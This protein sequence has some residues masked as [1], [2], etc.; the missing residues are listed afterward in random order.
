MRLNLSLNIVLKPFWSF[1]LIYYQPHIPLITTD[2]YITSTQESSGEVI[3]FCYRLK[4]STIKTAILSGETKA[5]EEIS[6]LTNAGTGCRACIFR[7]ER[8]GLL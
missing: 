7:V 3:C 2:K 8:L 6:A 1:I 5:I 4:A